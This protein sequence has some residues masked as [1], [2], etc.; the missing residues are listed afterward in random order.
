MKI[1]IDKF[2][3]WLINKGLKTVTIDHYLYYFNKF[4]EETFS[5]ESISRFL[6]N[7]SN[8]NTVARGFLVNLKKFLLVNYKELNIEK[9]RPTILEVELPQI[10]GRRKRREVNPLSKDE[11]N[12]LEKHLNTEKE[13]LELL[14]T[15]YG[16]G[17]RLSGLL[18]VKVVS[19]NWTKWKEDINKS[20]DLRVF[21][22]GDKE[23]VVYIPSRIMKRVAKFIHSSGISS[24]DSYLFIN[25][26]KENQKIKNLARTW[27]NKLRQAGIDSGIT[28][29]G[30][31]GKPIK[32][33]VVHPHR[34]R[35]SF[36]SHFQ[37]EQGDLRKTQKV[38]G[39][40]DISSTQIYTHVDEKIIKDDLNDFY[41]KQ[42]QTS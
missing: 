21:E 10:T 19:F 34:I 33:T 6:S 28:Q 24:P 41:S 20:G 9:L 38:L 1:P 42:T 15:Y 39:H 25:P 29:I 37:T 23:R 35:H 31:D 26:T 12:I 14:I 32:E 4:T 13:K 2:E 17:L 3:N 22:K 30:R 18:K 11:I 27:Q 40:S 36:A 16:Q 8:R 5:Q 7:K